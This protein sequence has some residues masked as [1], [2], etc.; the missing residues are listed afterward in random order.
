M[1]RKKLERFG[2]VEIVQEANFFFFSELCWGG[3]DFI[4][5]TESGFRSSTPDMGQY[6]K[7]GQIWRFVCS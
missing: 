1:V 2:E 7:E 6:T 3:M 5:K 4:K